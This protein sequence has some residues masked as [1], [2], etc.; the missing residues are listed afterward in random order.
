MLLFLRGQMDLNHLYVLDL[1]DDLLP[2]GQPRQVTTEDGNSLFLHVPGVAW[3]RD[4]YDAIWPMTKTTPNFIKLY[5]A[6]I[7]GKGPIHPLPFV[8]P[9]R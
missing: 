7:A 4:A 3:T 8:E 2:L 9:R 5:R 1:N 6:P